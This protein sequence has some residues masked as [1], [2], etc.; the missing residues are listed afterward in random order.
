MTRDTSEFIL[1]FRRDNNE[2][3]VTRYAC[4]NYAIGA[5][6]DCDIVLLGEGI[7]EKHAQLTL[8][9]QGPSLTSTVTSNSLE[10]KSASE[11]D[12]TQKNPI[13]HIGPYELEIAPAETPL[14]A[15]ALQTI[16]Q[17]EETQ[18]GGHNTPVTGELPA[19]PPS[20][21]PPQASNQKAGGRRL[22]TMAAAIAFLGGASGL[23]IQINANT[24]N[25]VSPIETTNTENPA[26]SP[27]NRKSENDPYQASSDLPAQKPNASDEKSNIKESIIKILHEFDVP[28]A[29]LIKTKNKNYFEI[30]AFVKNKHEENKLQRKLANY[31]NIIKLKTY[32]NDKILENAKITLGNK[33]KNIL[34]S[35]TKNGNLEIY[36]NNINKKYEELIKLKLK[37]NLPML[38]SIKIHKDPYNENKIDNF[39]HN[40][41][42]VWLGPIPYVVLNGS[43]I[44]YINDTLPNGSKVVSI[45]KDKFSVLSNNKLH[46]LSIQVE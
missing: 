45:E 39:T 21:S 30:T 9:P 36:T 42:G 17:Q 44:A 6:I 13:Y 29:E 25:I 27:E 15:P 35:E 4:G 40:V 24:S 5:S 33:Y 8:T 26:L 11:Q 18:E 37:L 20:H 16:P 22:K 10:L 2:I 14:R 3:N 32:S 41:T 12:S 46:E 23:A 7:Q 34:K 28:P 1:T 43:Q 38:R 19:P 31:S